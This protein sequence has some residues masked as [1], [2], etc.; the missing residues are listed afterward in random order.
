LRL[1]RWPG[2]EQEPERNP[3]LMAMQFQPGPPPKDDTRKT[4]KLVT[5]DEAHRLER[6][7]DWLA[8]QTKIGRHYWSDEAVRQ[9]QQITPAPLLWRNRI[10]IC[11]PLAEVGYSFFWQMLTG[12]VKHIGWHIDNS[13]LMTNSGQFLPDAHNTMVKAALELPGWNYL[14]F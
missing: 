9:M 8:E 11:A 10:M 4:S 5:P 6:S 13:L 1:H 14:L 7:R 12:A 3:P 2:H